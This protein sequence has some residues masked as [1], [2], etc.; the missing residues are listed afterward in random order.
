MSNLEENIKGIVLKRIDYKENDAIINVL[1]NQGKLYG[2]YARGVKK[3][4]SKNSSALLV[5]SYADIEYFFKEKG[6][7][8]IKRAKSI[9]NYFNDINDYSKV[10]VAFMMLDVINDIAKLQVKDNPFL[11]KLLD[12]SL[13]FINDIDE[14][15]LLSYFLIAIMKN[16]GVMLVVDHCALCKSEVINYISIEDG[17]FVCHNCNTNHNLSNYD[18]EIL[19][20]FRIINKVELDNLNLIESSKSNNKKLLEI[21]NGFYNSYTGLN[22]KNFEKMINQ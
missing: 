8:T 22:I 7:L 6:L 9:K 15:L 1:S 16:Q 13:G 4:K 19:K 21:I 12:K 3:I 20:L 14:S 18:V 2:F 11:F 17:G 5:F 10:I